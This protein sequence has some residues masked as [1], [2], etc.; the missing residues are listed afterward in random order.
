[1]KKNLNDPIGNRTRNLP[2]CS[3]VRIISNHTI[4]RKVSC[5]IF[6]TNVRVPSQVFLVGISGKLSSR[7]ERFFL[8]LLLSLH[9][10]IPI[11]DRDPIL[12]HVIIQG[13]DNGPATA[14]S[15]KET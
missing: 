11:I 5:R 15:F 12:I 6:I 7:G 13:I 9:N 10:A 4:A 1:V 8:A 2:A 3:S 14:R